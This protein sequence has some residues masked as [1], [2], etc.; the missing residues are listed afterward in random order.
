[1]D[2]GDTIYE[3]YETEQDDVADAANIIPFDPAE[4]Q[5]AG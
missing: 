2:P 4:I 1:M 3:E 5:D